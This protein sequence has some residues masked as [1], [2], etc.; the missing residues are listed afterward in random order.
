MVFLM[1]GHVAGGMGHVVLVLSYG[2]SQCDSMRLCWWWWDSLNERVHIE[3]ESS[4]YKHTH[5]HVYIYSRLIKIS[6]YHGL[7]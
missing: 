3:A 5:I 1:Q 4:V 7:A 6:L 2:D